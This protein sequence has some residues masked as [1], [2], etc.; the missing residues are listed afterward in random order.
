MK[1]PFSTF[2]HFYTIGFNNE[3]CKNI[4]T[5][6][7]FHIHSINFNFLL[8]ESFNVTMLLYFSVNNPGNLMVSST[9]SDLN[10]DVTNKGPFTYL[11][12]YEPIGM[13]NNHYAWQ[14]KKSGKS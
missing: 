6:V 1:Q 10:G 11:G 14:M 2:R 4:S 9:A 3:K 12:T 5:D 13:K 7:W 8:T